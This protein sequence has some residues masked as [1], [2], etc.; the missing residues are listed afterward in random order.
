MRTWAEIS[1]GTVRYIFEAPDAPVGMPGVFYCDITDYNPQPE[2]LDD[3]NPATKTFSKPESNDPLDP[4]N[5]EKSWC[6]VRNT[7]NTALNL[8]DY[9]QMP[10][11]PD[12]VIQKR[13]RKYRQELRDLPQKFDYPYKVVYP[14]SPYQNINNIK[15]TF[16]EKI[17]YV[18]SYI[19]HRRIVRSR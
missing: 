17:Q 16:W 18:W 4:R 14:L 7:R 8:S 9:T 19:K 15:L 13:F 3:Y 2:K 10:D 12:K 5:L 6:G 11:F 1:H